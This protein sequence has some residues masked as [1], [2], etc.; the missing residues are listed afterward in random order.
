MTI[1]EKDKT[2]CAHIPLDI[3]F[4]VEHFRTDKR[5]FLFTNFNERLLLLRFWFSSADLDPVLSP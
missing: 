4:F 1:S 5:L 2:Y 3:V